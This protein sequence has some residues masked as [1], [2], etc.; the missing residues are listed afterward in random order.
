MQDLIE[1]IELGD[2][3]LD[4]EELQRNET[5]NQ[6]YLQRYWRQDM[7]PGKDRNGRDIDGVWIQLPGHE[8]PVYV[9][10]EAHVKRLLLESGGQV[11]YDPRPGERRKP[12]AI[13]DVH[14]PAATP[15]EPPAHIQKIDA[16]EKD[17]S[18]LKAG[19]GQII[20]LLQAQNAKPE[21][22]EHKPKK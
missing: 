19:M 1:D 12:R 13:V 16:L 20:A 5:R 17:V 3:H 9:N 2:P 22:E 8:K 4:E 10:Q 18:E 6:K 11:V 15:P 21:Q 7:A 14:G